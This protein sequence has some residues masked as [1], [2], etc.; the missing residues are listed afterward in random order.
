MNYYRPLEKADRD[1]KPTGLWH[2]TVT[3]D[4]TKRTH[5]V[6]YCANGCEGHPTPD[7]AR[8][9]YKEYRLDHARYNAKLSG[10]QKKC[11]VCGEWTQGAAEIAFEMELHVLCDQHRNRE[12]LSKL[13]Q[14]GDAFGSY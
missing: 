3:N 7:G 1:G 14:V 12:E 8:E 11:E 9:H 5:P 4:N 13:V 10:V 2:Y 6:G